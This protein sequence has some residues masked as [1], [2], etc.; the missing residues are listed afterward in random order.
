M[1]FASLAEKGSVMDTGVGASTGGRR[2]LRTMPFSKDTFRLITAKFYTHSSIARVISRADIPVFSG[3]ETQMGEVDGPMYN[4]YG[5]VYWEASQ[6]RL[7]ILT[8]W[9]YTIAGR[10]TLGTRIWL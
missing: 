1:D 9:Q 7:R 4:A 3:V 10:P 5:K 6:T 8:S 2:S